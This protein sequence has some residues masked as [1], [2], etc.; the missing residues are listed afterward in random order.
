M[1]GEDMEIQVKTADRNLLL[2]ISGELDHH[3]ARD[4]LRELEL[5]V[6]AALPQAENGKP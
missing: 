6:E 5:A 3:G 1:G 2:E 4:A